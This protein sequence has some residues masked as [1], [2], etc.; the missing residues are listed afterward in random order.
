MAT[1]CIYEQHHDRLGPHGSTGRKKEELGEGRR[2]YTRIFFARVTYQG[3][4]LN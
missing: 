4:G 2:L 3:A 1:A